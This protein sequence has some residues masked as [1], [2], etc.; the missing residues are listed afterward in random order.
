MSDSRAEQLIKE[1]I[2]QATQRELPQLLINFFYYNN[3]TVADA[4]EIESSPDQ[5]ITKVVRNTTTLVFKK[6]KVSEDPVGTYKYDYWA[7]EVISEGQLVFGIEVKNHWAGGKPELK[8]ITAYIPGAWEEQLKKLKA[9]C[10]AL[11]RQSAEI[12]T[13]EKRQKK[14]RQKK[15]RLARF[16]FDEE[17]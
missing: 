11:T 14:Q 10:D 8:E 5:R 2:S 3:A 1:R 13:A 17:T 15:D 16:G 7:Y 4:K 6:L 9:E 12:A